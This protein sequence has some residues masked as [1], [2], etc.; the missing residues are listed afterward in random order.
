M[1]TSRSITTT[2]RISAVVESCHVYGGIFENWLDGRVEGV[3]NVD[4][5]VVVGDK[6]VLVKLFDEMTV[7]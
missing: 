7:E 5:F 1:P 6:L 4:L 3:L 2:A